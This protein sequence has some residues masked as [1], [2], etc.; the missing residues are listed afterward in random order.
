MVQQMREMKRMHRLTLGNISS[1]LISNFDIRRRAKFFSKEKVCRGG[2]FLP[3]LKQR[4]IFANYSPP[5][6][7]GQPHFLPPQ[8]SGNYG[9]CKRILKLCTVTAVWPLPLVKA[10]TKTEKRGK[11]CLCQ[12]AP[13]LRNCWRITS[14][15]GYLL[16]K[17]CPKFHHPQIVCRGMFS[18]LE[19]GLDARVNG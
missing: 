17:L 15:L 1:P 5:F 2:T 18:H 11:L 19:R 12:F 6:G 13:L 14:L 16:E 4:G 8:D 3:T 9:T 7:K 10:A